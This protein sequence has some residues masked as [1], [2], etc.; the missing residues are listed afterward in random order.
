[1]IWQK[2]LKEGLTL[3]NGSMYIMVGESRQQE[4]ESLS[5]IKN[6]SNV[7]MHAHCSLHL[8]HLNTQN[9]SEGM[10]L[11]TSCLLSHFN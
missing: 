7:C 4:L 3:A 8:L 6:K 2:Q 9:P 11:S 5:I 1:M 10:I